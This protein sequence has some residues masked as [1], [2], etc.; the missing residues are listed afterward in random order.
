LSRRHRTRITAREKPVYEISV[1][2]LP[3]VA[4]EVLERKLTDE[5]IVVVGNSVDDGA[6]VWET[7]LKLN[8][9]PD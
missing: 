9:G 6:I 3:R 4:I 5:E 2:D 7:V 1:D 8:S